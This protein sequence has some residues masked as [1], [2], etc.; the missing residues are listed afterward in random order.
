MVA[1]FFRVLTNIS[2]IAMPIFWFRQIAELSEDLSNLGKILLVVP[3]VI[4]YTGFGLIGLGMLIGMIGAYV[5]YRKG[6]TWTESEEE[7][8]LDG[9]SN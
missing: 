6:W 7:Q 8:L 2:T 3:F 4:Q 9:T 1:F 5:T